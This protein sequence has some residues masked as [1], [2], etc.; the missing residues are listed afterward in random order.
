MVLAPRGYPSD[1]RRIAFA[2]RDA[3]YTPLQAVK[4]AAGQ[5]DQG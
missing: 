4:L 5:T 1:A 3:L 2:D